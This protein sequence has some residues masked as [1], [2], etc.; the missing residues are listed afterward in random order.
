MWIERIFSLILW[1]KYQFA[2][3]LRKFYAKNIHKKSVIFGNLEIVTF[4]CMQLCYYMTFWRKYI[5]SPW[6][7]QR[8]SRTTFLFSTQDTLNVVKL[9]RV[10]LSWLAVVLL[11]VCLCLKKMRP[12]GSTIS[13]AWPINC[14]E[15]GTPTESLLQSRWWYLFSNIQKMAE[16]LDSMKWSSNCFEP[17]IMVTITTHI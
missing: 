3:Y 8:N 9:L 14:I 7:R 1:R 15:Y 11:T 13:P 17:Y 5:S 12:P 4:P 2:T 10:M 6:T 16:M